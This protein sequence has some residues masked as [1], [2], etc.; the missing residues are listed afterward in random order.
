MFLK[1]IYMNTPIEIDE[2][3]WKEVGLDLMDYPVTS[4]LRRDVK[5]LTIL[6]Q[7]PKVLKGNLNE[8]IILKKNNSPL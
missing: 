8:K 4:R 3:Y 7:N 1:G 6:R 2:D 5:D